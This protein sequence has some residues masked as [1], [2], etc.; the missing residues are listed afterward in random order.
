[1]NHLNKKIKKGILIV[2]LLFTNMLHAQ[3]TIENLL[4][5]PFPTDLKSSADGKHIAWVFNNQGIR[6]LIIADAPDFKPRQLTNHISD[7]GVDI[8][9]VNFTPDGNKILFTEGN[10]NNA[11]GEA[12]NPALLQIKTENIV[13]IVNTDGKDLKKSAVVTMQQH[14]RIIKSLFLFPKEK[15]GLY[16]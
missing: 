4:S 10:P 13:W 14:P 8:S 6:N 1:M 7:D 9:S 15:S 11:K 12:A 5:V 2:T 16:H 3:V